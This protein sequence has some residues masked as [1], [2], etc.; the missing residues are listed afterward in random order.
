MDTVPHIQRSG[1]FAFLN[2][3]K[4]QGDGFPLSDL[5]T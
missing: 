4:A 3:I 2:D 5:Y 1:F